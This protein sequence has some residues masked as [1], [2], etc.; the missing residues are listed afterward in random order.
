[1]GAGKVV[2]I[3]DKRAVLSL[4]AAP[5]GRVET[6]LGKLEGS[7]VVERLA[8]ALQPRLEVCGAGAE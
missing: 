7:E 4:E 2:E 5:R 8:N 1:M 3:G 6:V